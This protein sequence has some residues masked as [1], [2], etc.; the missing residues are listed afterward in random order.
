MNEIWK[1]IPWSEWHYKV[2]SLWSVKSIKF[3]KEKILKYR[4]TWNGYF[5]VDIVNW[6]KK[7][8]WKIHRLICEL[9]LWKIDW[10]NEVN[11]KNWIKSDNRVENLEWC[12]RGENNID[13]IKNRRDNSNKRLPVIQKD[14]EWNFIKKW[15]TPTE[16][17]KYLN[18]NIP[19]IFSCL[20]WRQKTCWWF[21][22]CR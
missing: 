9:F 1:D 20:A 5:C 16:A 12:T 15:N 8:K 17:W 6:D 3:S 22:W 14:I 13:S 18:I 21:L 4:N 11:H 7:E 10:K 2:S 19:S